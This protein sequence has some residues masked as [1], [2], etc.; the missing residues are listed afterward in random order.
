MHPDHLLFK[1]QSTEEEN[2]WPVAKILSKTR[3]TPRRVECYVWVKVSIVLGRSVAVGWH[4]VLR[5][6]PS[7]HIAFVGRCAQL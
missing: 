5:A 1:V 2:F 6:G 7:L 4:F 3:V